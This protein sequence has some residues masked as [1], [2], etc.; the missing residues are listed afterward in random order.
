LQDVEA[1]MV[2]VQGLTPE[3]G[4]NESLRLLGGIEF[5]TVHWLSLVVLDMG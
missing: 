1:V 3:C 4:Q 5:D 2:L